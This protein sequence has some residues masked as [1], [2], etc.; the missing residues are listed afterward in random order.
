MDEQKEISC[1]LDE[2]Q[3][4]EVLKRQ[5]DFREDRERYATDEEMAALWRKCGL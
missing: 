1:R 2:E 5:Q 4:N 3:V